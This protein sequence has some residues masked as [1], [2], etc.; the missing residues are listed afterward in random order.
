MSCSLGEK[1]HWQI[2]AMHLVADLCLEHTSSHLMKEPV[3]RYTVAKRQ[4]H[5][6]INTIGC[7][8]QRQVKTEPPKEVFSLF[9]Q[10]HRSKT[11][12]FLLY[13]KPNHFLSTRDLWLTGSRNWFKMVDKV[14]MKVVDSKWLERRSTS[15]WRSLNETFGPNTFLTIMTSK[16]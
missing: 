8:Y 3:F 6:Q 5:L 12:F 16:L 13:C 9:T 2:S 7:V 15:D 4:G 1:G 14:V 11:F 10:S